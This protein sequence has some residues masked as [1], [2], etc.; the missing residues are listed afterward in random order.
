[1][2][3]FQ[4]WP[5]FGISPD[6]LRYTEVREAIDDLGLKTTRLRSVEARILPKGLETVKS[7]PILCLR[8]QELLYS[9]KVSW[10]ETQSI[11]QPRIVGAQRK[12]AADEVTVQDPETRAV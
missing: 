1:M 12:Q 10:V 3:Q 2:R 6:S 8:V 5:S 7:K 11:G 4:H 9:P